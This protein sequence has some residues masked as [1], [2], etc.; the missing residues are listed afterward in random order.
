MLLRLFVILSL[1][2]WP[3]T[4]LAADWSQVGSS[5][6]PVNL[7]AD[8][9]TYNKQTGLYRA[10]G[11]VQLKQGNTELHS[12]I[13]W[14]NQASSEV[15]A[16]G[17]VELISPDEKMVGRKLSYNLNAGT[18]TVED[19]Y[20]FLKEQNLHIHGR[21]IERRGK[22]DYRVT[23]GTFTTCDGEVPSWK[24][25][26]SQLDVT[27]SG[28]ARAKHATFYLKDIPSFYVPYML[29]PIKSERES[30]LL[31]PSVGYS[32][33][34]GF[35]YSGAYYLVIAENQD[36]TLYVDYL[37]EMGIGTG[38]EYRYNFGRDNVGEARVYHIDVNKVDGELVDEQRY[39]LEWQHSGYLPAGIRAAVDAEYVND[40]QYFEDFGEVA[41]E[42]NKDKVESYFSLSK[43]WGK[44]NLVGQ[45]RYTKDLENDAAD[46]VQYLPRIS[47]D[48]ARQRIND[49]PLYYALE[50]DYTYF[51][52]DEGLSGQRLMLRPILSAS[53][54]LLDVIEITPEVAYRD[55]YYW[56][57]DDASD[58]QQEGLVEFSTRINTRLQ[59]VY[60]LPLGPISK[61]RHTLEPEVIY[62]YTPITAAEQSHL[63][64]Y[65]SSDR[66]A[67]ANLVEYALVSRL[68]ARFDHEG[69]DSTYR[70]LVYL[71]LSQ[72]YGLLEEQQE[73]PFSAIR[74]Q[75]TLLPT[76]WSNLR[77]DVTYDIDRGG[78]SKFSAEAEV[79]DQR[80]NAVRIDYRYDRAA[81]IDYGA[82]KLD[83]AFLKPVYLSYEKRYD[84]SSNERL[85]D[86][87]GIEYR[88]DCWS[89]ELTYREHELNSTIMLTFT[90]RG[91]GS[92]GG[93]SGSL[94]G[95]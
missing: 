33:K 89:T 41:D 17:D 54:R 55:R 8:Q 37:S 69:G 16:E 38:L 25:G 84:F 19:G 60:A 30:G 46:P 3:L 61:L 73:I 82:I 21:Q 2:Y 90:M 86:V 66:I 85:E 92:V 34:R 39:A 76:D 93:F 56:G 9:L 35:Q 59:R 88:Q 95:S 5:Q 31:V 77:F 23:D 28:Y 29:Y 20:V 45:A 10:T 18:G 91:I 68:T 65:E 64:Y 4:A 67:E 36:A 44:F 74:G 94:G 63:P 57:Q 80:E 78:W 27:L 51:S 75:L 50:T 70:D 40:D 22:M 15:E 6:V 53:L 26:A 72:S 7:E 79:H 49:T 43:N 14:W 87:V 13:L 52:R 1:L 47:F 83:V 48:A 12:R 32:K 24:F 62:R 71:R 11:N 42:Y 58:N 81:I